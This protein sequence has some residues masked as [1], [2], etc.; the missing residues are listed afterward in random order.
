M[1][2]R[3]IENLGL[4]FYVLRFD[5]HENK[6]ESFNIFNNVYVLETVSDIYNKK[7]CKENV[8][9]RLNSAFMHEFW[10]RYQYE[11][12]VTPKDKKQEPTRVDCYDQLKPNINI[13]ADYV[14]NRLNSIK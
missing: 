3:D 1:I 5:L 9:K 14:Y 6:L 7:L 10:S 8:K 12:D 4:E 11:I 13:V 2:N